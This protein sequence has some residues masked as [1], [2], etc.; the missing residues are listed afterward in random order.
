MEAGRGDNAAVA[1]ASGDKAVVMRLL[2]RSFIETGIALEQA[3]TMI[4]PAD[5]D[6]LAAAFG[7]EA[8]EQSVEEP[9]APAAAE[10]V[11]SST[12]LSGLRD[13]GGV[14]VSMPQ[15][16]NKPLVLSSSLGPSLLQDDSITNSSTMSLGSW[17]FSLFSGGDAQSA[18]NAFDALS[19]TG[20][21]NGAAKGLGSDAAVFTQTSAAVTALATGTSSPGKEFAMTSSM[22]A[23]LNL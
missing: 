3:L 2:A 4:Q 9:T 1:S 11:I 12:Q 23:A 18:L 17:G 8:K 21:D 15:Q 20:R 19:H 7:M 14:Q 13:L 16:I 10:G 5:R 6:L 22:L